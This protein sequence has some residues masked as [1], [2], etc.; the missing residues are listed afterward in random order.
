LFSNPVICEQPQPSD[1]QEGLKKQ[2][3]VFEFDIAT[4]EAA[5][6]AFD[7]KEAIIPQRAKVASIN[8]KWYG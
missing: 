6:K 8:G 4:W 2:Q 5:I 3:L 1:Y 7:I